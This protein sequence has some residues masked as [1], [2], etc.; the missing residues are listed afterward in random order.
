[1]LA[2][3]VLA[4]VVAIPV[5]SARPM[6]IVLIIADDFG[7]TDIGA[8]NPGCFYETPGLDALASSGVNFTRGYAA[9]P[10][11]SPTRFS[12]MSG[13]NP[14]VDAATEWFGEGPARSERFLSADRIN[15]LPTARPTIAEYLRAAGYETFFAG[16]WHLG[17]DARHLPQNRGFDV[18]IAGCDKGNPGWQGGYFAPYADFIGL[19][20]PD[21][22]HLPARLTDETIGWMNSRD[23]SRPFLAVLSYY[24]V[25]TPL[26]GR[27]DL[28]N[29]YRDRRA[30]L[31]LDDADRFADE[32]QIWPGDTPRKVR[33]E[34][35]HAVY[36]AMVE[37]MDEQIGRLVDAIDKAG[38][39]DDTLIVFVS[40]NGG[41][42]TSEGSPT[43]NTPLRAGKGW[44]YEGGIRVPF[45][46]RWPGITEPGAVV[47]E[48]VHTSDIVPTILEAAGVET[49]SIVRLPASPL[50]G[51]SLRVAAGAAPAERP[52]FFH[53]P[54]Y[55]NQ[56]GFPG[57][58]IIRGDMK[59]V[60]RYEDGV[61]RLYDLR[62]DPGETRDLAA[63]RPEAASAMRS[64]L[65]GWLGEHHARFLTA[66]SDGPTPWHPGSDNSSDAD[67]RP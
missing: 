2:G 45:M 60:L 21:G 63:G 56:G 65:L 67:R 59:Y 25:H 9:A 19:D 49:G 7:W 54:H 11:C 12:I 20:A 29:K 55:G 48:P 22:E 32:E 15:H 16:K 43:A 41:L 62:S 23:G 64:E 1:M 36:A 35:D 53:Y 46:M 14:A 10:V 31:G 13:V 51:R 33:I 18:N 52:L 40:D 57:G 66:R 34:Q 27:E 37:A 30:A 17:G 26:Q 38:L 28:V 61:G 47:D 6:N 39:G 5:A 4:V 50:E 3:F 42:S 8:N 44:L 58:A 24:S